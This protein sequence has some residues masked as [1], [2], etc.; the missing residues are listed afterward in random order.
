M[1]W[2]SH[3]RGP[4]SVSQGPRTDTPWGMDIHNT[5]ETII[6]GLREKRTGKPVDV[7]PVGT[8]PNFRLFR[9]N[10]I[11]RGSLGWAPGEPTRGRE[12][13]WEGV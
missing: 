3:W 4:H 12:A 13:V 5:L 7:P 8:V 10:R 1:A 2:L 9:E 11:L 6:A